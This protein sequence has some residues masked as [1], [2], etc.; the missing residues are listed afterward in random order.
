[1]GAKV[2]VTLQGLAEQLALPTVKSFDAAPCVT[3][4]TEAD[5]PV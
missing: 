1:L 5:V 2:T 4:A 3:A